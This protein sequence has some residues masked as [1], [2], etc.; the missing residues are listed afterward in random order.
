MIYTLAWCLA[1]HETEE[2]LKIFFKNIKLQ[3]GCITPQ[4]FMSDI[5]PQFYEAFCSVNKYRPR[6][7]ICTWHVDKAWKEE[8]RKKIKNTEVEAG[9][10]KLLR[11][12]LEQTD[13]K[14]FDA[15]LSSLVTRLQSSVTDEFRNYFL[16]YWVNNKREWGYC[17]RVGD[18]IN[19]NMFV[20]AFHKTFKYNYLKGKFNK[21]VDTVLVNLLKFSRD[22]TFGRLIK[23]TKGKSTQRKRMLHER[24][25]ASMKLPFNYV[26]LKEDDSY[27][28]KS[29][30]GK[31]EYTTIKVRDTC[32][33]KECQMKCFECGICA[34][35]FNCSCPDFLLNSVSC[36]H[37]HL[38]KRYLLAN[39]KRVKEEEKDE[40]PQNVTYDQDETYLSQQISTAIASLEKPKEISTFDQIKQ[41]AKGVALTL[42]QRIESCS[43]LDEEA[44]VHLQKQMSSSLNTF[45]AMCK[46]K[47]VPVMKQ[48]INIPSHKNIIPQNNF[49]STKKKRKQN[50]NVRFAKPTTEEKDNF[51]DTLSWQTTKMKVSVTDEVNKVNDIVPIIKDSVP[52]N[53]GE[54][55][56]GI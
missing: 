27:N 33:N 43:N 6:K 25:L 50:S 18:G 51:F 4:W 1:N 40:L 21:R 9:V 36:K 14:L 35:T 47:H 24:H 19:T 10:Y 16:K 49:Y 48:T 54:C 56:Y 34:H 23:L 45:D 17:F 31:R 7:L 5:A 3:V 11:T 52:L 55:S 26:T 41:K 44:L 46:H 22:K 28:I 38:L 29:E 53:K 2:F 42:L 20:E 13:E 8:L 32:V 37:M 15:H 12:V 30:D 39:N